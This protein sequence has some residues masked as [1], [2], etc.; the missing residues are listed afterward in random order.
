MKYLKDGFNVIHLG[1]YI[2]GATEGSKET[3]AY[4]EYA[5]YEKIKDELETL[6][7]K[8]KEIEANVN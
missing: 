4:I 6:K 3:I 7:G 5:A 8:K 2:S 1:K